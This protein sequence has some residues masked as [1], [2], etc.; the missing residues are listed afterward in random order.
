VFLPLIYRETAEKVTEIYSH[1][2]TEIG[3]RVSA[4]LRPTYPDN[5]SEANL[6]SKV[7]ALS[8]AGILEID[9]YL[10]DTWRPKNLTWVANALSAN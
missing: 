4:I 7:S 2:K 6:I 3:G 8:K 10:L 1:Y 9:F 5:D